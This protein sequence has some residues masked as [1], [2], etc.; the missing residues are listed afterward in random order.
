MRN[1]RNHRGYL[2]FAGHR[3]TGLLLSLFLPIHFLVLGLAL[4][5]EDELQRF[6]R[7]SDLPLVK[8][9]EWGLVLL[10]SLH[11]CFGVRLL[12]LELFAWPDI[13]DTRL[14]WIGWGAAISIGVGAVFLVG[15][16]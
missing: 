6:I 13:R 7:F 10:L 16:I 4:E 15:V 14:G 8:F 3:L 9:A 5:G 12:A 11:F 2:A 1:P